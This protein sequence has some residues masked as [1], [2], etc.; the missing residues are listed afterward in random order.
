MI[1]P[2]GL[3]LKFGSFP[4]LEMLS[5]E[6]TSVHW[7]NLKKETQERPK[8]QVIAQGMFN[9]YVGKN[10][11]EEARLLNMYSTHELEEWLKSSGICLRNTSYIDYSIA[12]AL[13]GLI[14]EASL[15]HASRAC[16][17]GI[18]MSRNQGYLTNL[19]AKLY[20]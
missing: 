14:K 13:L 2:H 7:L 9:T 15:I 1:I 11:E 17:T 8:A 10:G 19:A 16:I 20:E 6:P 3:K 5:Q 12:D 4:P 18:D